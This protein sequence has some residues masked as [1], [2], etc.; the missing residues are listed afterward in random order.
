MTVIQIAP[1][2]EEYPVI[3]R[4][5]NSSAIIKFP[6]RAKLKKD[7]TPKNVKCN[8]KKGKK[9][10]VY[11]FEIEDAKK[12]VEYF[13]DNEMWLHFLIFVLSC[14]MARRIN[15]TLSLHWFHLFNP[16]SGNIRSDLLEI[17]E[18][19]T[20]KLA[21]PKINSACRSAIALYIEKT[22]CN[23]SDENYQH[24]VFLQL[25]GTYKG[26]VITD[27][28]YRKALKKAAKAV[29]IEYNVGTHSTRKTF[30]MLNRMLHPGDYD[31]MEILQTIY[32]HSD[33]KTTKH[34]IGLTKQKVDKYYD[35]MGSFF[36]NY[37]VGE[38]EY[39][40]ISKTPI[41]S[42][43]TNDLRDII[44][45]AYEAGRNNADNPDA[46]CHVEAIT[47]MMGIIES[48]AK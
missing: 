19:K 24:P 13:K 14:N 5:E 32:N 47:D 30:G 8:K 15:D 43:D 33:T 27:D 18:D 9:S 1:Q 21:N 10:E 29:G 26:N 31:S 4:A 28:G 44:K 38:K 36:D 48:L 23:P 35:D 17:S 6:K 12:V 40:S 25:S 11:P 20:D 39:Q 37:I 46:M 3:R 16:E 45:M 22:K 7:G 2:V 42:I 41:V 34:Y